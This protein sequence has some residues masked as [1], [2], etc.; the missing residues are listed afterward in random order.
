M[1]DPFRAGTYRYHGRSLR[2]P[3]ASAAQAGAGRLRARDLRSQ[4]AE[5]L[6]DLACV[7]PR[8][9]PLEPDPPNPLAIAIAIAAPRP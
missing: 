7:A 6:K 3:S 4:G 2:R 8:G 9:R 5:R 1:S